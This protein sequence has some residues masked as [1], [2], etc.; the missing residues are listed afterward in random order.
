MSHSTL[1]KAGEGAFRGSCCGWRSSYPWHL[2][3]FHTLLKSKWIQL[4]PQP[5]WATLTRAP[6]GARSLLVESWAA[7]PTSCLLAG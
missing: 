5:Y 1:P 7:L 4:C 6:V 3:A 2:P